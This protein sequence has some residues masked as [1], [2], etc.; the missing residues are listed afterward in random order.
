[1]ESD[2]SLGEHQ[3]EQAG[4]IRRQSETIRSL[5]GDLNLTMRLDYE[6]QPLRRAPLSPAALIRQTAA[7]FLNGGLDE[8]YSI[9]VQIDRSAQSLTLEAD[10]F[11]HVFH[12]FILGEFQAVE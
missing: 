7:D 11:L 9:E 12:L 2:G 6:M 8:K 5:V 3:R 4:I 1:M 10:Q